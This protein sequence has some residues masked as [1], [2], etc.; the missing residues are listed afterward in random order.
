MRARLVHLESSTTRASLRG[1]KIEVDVYVIRG[2]V[3][4]THL[5]HTPKS[6]IAI[7]LEA[8]RPFTHDFLSLIDMVDF[9]CHRAIKGKPLRVDLADTALDLHEI[10]IDSRRLFSA[11]PVGF[12]HFTDVDDTEEV[13]TNPLKGCRV[14][15]FER[16]R[17]VG[18][19]DDGG[20]C[21]GAAVAATGR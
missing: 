2:A 1:G 16:P 3:R 14:L 10:A 7:E 21:L 4:V 11:D 9:S 18:V 19:S 15:A 17:S 5:H 12:S 13:P 6:T 8:Q 20:W